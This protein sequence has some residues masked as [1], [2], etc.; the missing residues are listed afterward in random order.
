MFTFG[1][2]FGRGFGQ[3]FG[4]EIQ[5]NT[6]RNLQNFLLALLCCGL[7]VAC[8]EKKLDVQK[9]QQQASAAS[10]AG[11][12]AAALIH[13]KSLLQLDPKNL[14][15]RLQVGR[16]HLENAQPDVAEREFRRAFELGAPQADVQPLIFRAMFEQRLYDKLL[17]ESEGL[18]QANQ[19]DAVSLSYRGMAL[20]GQAKVEAAQVMFER[21][22]QRTPALPLA[23]LGQARVAFAKGQ[24]ET[25]LTQINGVLIE[26]PTLSEALSVRA[27]MYL[28]LNRREQAIAAYQ[29]LIAAQPRNTS[30]YARLVTLLCEAQRFDEAQQ[31]I[32]TLNKSSPPGG[33][34]DYLEALVLFHKNDLPNARKKLVASN[35]ELPNFVPAQVLSWRIEL[36][37]HQPAQAIKILTAAV[38]LES[39]HLQAR[40]L[41]ANAL[42][43]EKQ[44]QQ[45]FEALRPVLGAGVNSAALYELA[46]MALLQSNDARLAEQYLA[47]AGK[48]APDA[49]RIQSAL[50]LSRL[51]TQWDKADFAALRKPN[52]PAVQFPYR[53]FEIARMLGASQPAQWAQ[54]EKLA[55]RLTVD[56][57]KQ[58]ISYNLLGTV[59]GKQSRL[60]Q[61]REAFEHALQLDPEHSPALINLAQL[62]INQGRRAEAVAQIERALQ[63]QPTSLALLLG[64]AEIGRRAGEQPEQIAQW[65]EK[66]QQAHPNILKPA[67]LAV[68][69]YLEVGDPAHALKTAQRAQKIAPNDAEIAELLGR[70]LAAVGDRAG[71]LTAYAHLVTLRPNEALPLLFLARAQSTD[72]K[73]ASAIQ[74]LQKALQFKP[75]LVEAQ[76]ELILLYARLGQKSDAERQLAALKASR[77]GKAAPALV[78]EVEADMAMVSKQPLQAIILYRTLLERQPSSEVLR[79][80]H[81]ALLAAGRTE[82]AFGFTQ[83]WFKQYPNDLKN[84]LFFAVSADQQ[85][86]PKIAAQFYEAAA[87]IKPDDATILNNLASATT[88]FDPARA[89]MIAQQARQSAPDDPIL[90]DTQGW[91]MVA[92]GQAAAGLKLIEQAS[93]KAPEN[94]SIAY[95]HAVAL[96]K[97]GD[98]VA[99]RL[100]IDEVLTKNRRFAEEEEAK[101]FRTQLGRP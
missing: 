85:H 26:Q 43:Q 95:H 97:A 82:E 35:R 34:V 69:H 39:G 76:I 59:Y 51:A 55:V 71:A 16:E 5:R 22:L 68:R 20:F 7:L 52:D 12:H 72:G 44:P 73:T 84:L 49:A 18:L 30:T 27:D 48:L 46:G 36:A 10:A 81:H 29:A 9:L 2:G 101:S 33:L 61:A 17:E 28:I 42:L 99:A 56:Y 66:A 64:R 62:E 88:A 32:Q 87:K 1:Q 58:A 60:P 96:L 41:L 23:R 63:K 98:S 78:A 57:P 45:A 100:R 54:A 79:K 74:N 21:A 91:A 70:S 86:Q 75:D 40:M 24:V 14:Q 13:Y 31:A 37:D 8:K 90:M 38:Q 67:L 50:E 19:L 92:Q 65:L 3:E 83:A 47:Y 25:A 77:L 15:L 93:R 80:L 6:Q 89:V 94:L 53:V 11:D 4:A